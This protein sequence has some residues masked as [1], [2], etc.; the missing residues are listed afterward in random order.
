L[1]GDLIHGQRGPRRLFRRRV[2]PVSL[3]DPRGY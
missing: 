1:G 2:C 3:H